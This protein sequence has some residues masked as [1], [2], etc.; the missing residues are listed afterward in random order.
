MRCGALARAFHTL[1]HHP[2]FITAT[3]EALPARLEDWADIRLLDEGDSA[4]GLTGYLAGMNAGLLVGDWKRPDAALVA[5]LRASGIITV[6]LGGQTGGATPDLLVRQNIAPLPESPGIDTLDGPDVLVLDPDYA[7]LPPREVAPRAQR[8]LVSLGG[9]PTPLLERIIG[10]LQKFAERLPIETDIRRPYDDTGTVPGL[11]TALMA[12]DIGILAGG[13]TIH[14]AAATGL[15]VICVPIADN[16]LAR[17][18]QVEPLGLGIRI[19]R[20]DGFE[21]RLTEALD[22]LIPDANRRAAMAQAGQSRIDGRGAER[23]A[24]AILDRFLPDSAES[25]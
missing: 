17:A 12:A 16:Q 10:V 4:A 8:I 25:Q 1:G 19:D 11:R 24:R 22:T 14:E 21:T 6:L 3:P 20:G 9:T 18:A 13:T 7:G 5:A 15:P 23:V 2:I